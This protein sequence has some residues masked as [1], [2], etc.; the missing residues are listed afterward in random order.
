MRILIVGVNWLGDALLSTAAIRAI[1]ENYPDSY[2]GCMIVPRVK[3]IFQDNPYLNEI[4]VYDEES[5]HKGFFKKLRFIQQLRK[6]DFD[7]VYLLH[8]SFTRTLLCYLSGIP[9]RIGYYTKKRGFLLT[10]RVLQPKRDSLH[11]LDFY[12]NILKAEGIQVKERDY[13]FIIRDE[14]REYINA[15]L[16]EEGIRDTDLLIAIN[17]GGNWKPKRWSIEN[18]SLL[19][20]RLKEEFKAKIVIT[21]SKEDIELA[22]KISDSM[23]ERPVSL[24]GKISLKQLGALFERTNLVITADTSPMHIASAVGTKLIC[25]FGPT[26]PNITGPVGKG[27]YRIIQKDIG[28]KIPCYRINCKDNLCMKAITVDDVME[29]VRELI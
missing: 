26:S 7:K 3:E 5:E 22:K 18:F 19:A 13:I 23:K 21:G 4:I 28:C 6:K 8:R 10:K 12:L 11:R 1:R 16:K 25:I 15:L 14:D 2:I 29:K 20:N 17:P 24:C 27:I 9:E